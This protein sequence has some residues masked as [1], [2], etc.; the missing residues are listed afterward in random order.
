[1]KLPI[2][3]AALLATLVSGHP[4]TSPAFAQPVA[5][6]WPQSTVRLILPLPPGTAADIAAR[7]LAERLSQRWGQPVIVENR[8]GGDA[9][10]AAVS[11]LAARDP[12]QLL[13]SFAGIVTTNPLT[14]SQL[15]YA[16][17]DLVPIVPVLENYFGAS[18][19]AAMQADT[20]SDL[21]NIAGRQP[22]A[23]NWAA[24]PGLPHYVM[25]ALQR[26]AGIQMVQVPYREF[27]PAIQDLTQGR[28]QLA[29]TSLP[30]LLPH[31]AS[32][33]AKLLFVTA[34]ERSP[35][36][37]HVPTAAEAGYPD[38][39]FEGVVGIYGWRGMPAEITD[40][41]SKDVQAITADPSFRA[42]VEA[43]GSMPRT[44]SAAE[45]A[46]AIEQQRAQVSALHEANV[47]PAQ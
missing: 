25:L 7:F 20:L 19:S 37:P 42:R 4:A 44:G 16:P 24:T 47:K 29:A 11:F 46:A 43:V 38:L 30:L 27:G 33:R 26:T 36:A 10:P 28:L 15:P 8:Q 6:T 9:I 2:A 17:Q 34:R 1:M 32:G 21:I 35:L 3:I 13:F 12:H 5:Q 23:L 31:H 45:F 41:V 22:G 40:R 39:T 14:H 18:A